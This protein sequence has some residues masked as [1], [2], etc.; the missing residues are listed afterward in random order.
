M[1]NLISIIT[2]VIDQM[3]EC[4]IKT[5]LLT[6]FPLQTE[7]LSIIED[8]FIH[9]TEK[10][11]AKET[12]NLFF[13][14]WS[15]TNNS[16]MTVAGL[17]NRMTMLVHKN[18]PINSE[19]DL[20]KSVASLNRIVDEDLAVVG[21]VLHSDL[22]YTM[23]TNIVG[24]DSWLSKQYLSDEA[25][26][27]K[28]WKDKNSLRDK[29]IMIGLLTTLVHEIYTHG[30]VEFI[31]PKF[32]RWLRADG[33]LTEQEIDYSLAWIRVH[34]GPTEKDHFFHA[35]DAVYSYSK[36]LYIDVSTYNLEEI[37]STYI[38]LKSRVMGTLDQQIL[39]AK[40]LQ[41]QH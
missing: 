18:K 30:E 32:E 39:E 1:K 22:F 26:E 27:F 36:A 16:A 25:K 21:R 28:A 9:L 33:L 4:H 8:S 20:F 40:T 29:D 41:H 13:K 6:Y 3:A 5:Q 38:I 7:N 19:H 35:V 23:A 34:C 12:L 17:S 31:I 2:P 14:S 37:I 24:D 10:K 11:Q 15:Q